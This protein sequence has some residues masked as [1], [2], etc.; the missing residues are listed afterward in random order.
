M[1]QWHAPLDPECPV[2]KDYMKTLFDDPM[3]QHY[4][5]GG[6]IM[7][8]WEPRHRAQC[9]RCQDYGAANIEVV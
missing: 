3:T 2:V 9:K 8:G 6:E 7:E 5:I 4:G 1:P